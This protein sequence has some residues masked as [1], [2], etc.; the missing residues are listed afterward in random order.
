VGINIT[1]NN[2]ASRAGHNGPEK[3]INWEKL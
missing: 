3:P 2:Q 1:A